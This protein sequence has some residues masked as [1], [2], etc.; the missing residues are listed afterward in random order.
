MTR[1]EKIV[2]SVWDLSDFYF[3]LVKISTT[4][5]FSTLISNK[6]QNKNKMINS[7]S[8]TSSSGNKS[9]FK[10]ICA[11]PRE[12]IDF[13]V[14]K[15]WYFVL[16]YFSLAK[17]LL[18]NFYSYNS[19]KKFKNLKE[20]KI[21]PNNVVLWCSMIITLFLAGLP[22]PPCYKMLCFS[23]PPPPPRGHNVIYEWPHT[24]WRSNR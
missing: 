21:F 3:Y 23:W 22:P 14:I 20:M 12:P 1:V 13:S 15:L 8:F 5:I 11:P 4:T 18:S 10:M 24:W 6:L 19:S 9:K 17:Y 7:T 16:F 2:L